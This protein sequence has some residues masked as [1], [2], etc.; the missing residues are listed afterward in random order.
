MNECLTSKNKTIKNFNYN[1]NTRE[2]ARNQSYGRSKTAIMTSNMVQQSLKLSEKSSSCWMSIF[3]HGYDVMYLQTWVISKAN[4]RGHGYIEAKALWPA[5]SYFI[6]LCELLRCRDTK[7]C[8]N[9]VTDS[10]PQRKIS[11]YWQWVPAHS[12]IALGPEKDLGII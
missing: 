10:E 1:Y 5:F 6:I 7:A 11:R 3:S 2:S 4:I 8:A 9:E 12:S